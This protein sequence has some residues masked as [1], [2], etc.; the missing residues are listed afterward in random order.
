MKNQKEL[1]KLPR[2]M[3]SYSYEKNGDIRYR[4]TI[5]G[6]SISVTGTSIAEV[7]KLMKA[8]EDETVRKIKAGIKK[9]STGT[10]QENMNEWM[11][12]Y[13]KEEVMD[14]YKR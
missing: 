14:C 1:P 4:K 7:N 6:N 10:L 8:K 5:D 11:T 12:L 2:G 9:E 13:K 3:G